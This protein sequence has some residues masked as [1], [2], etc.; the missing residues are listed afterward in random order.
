MTGV[1]IHA[2]DVPLDALGLDVRLGN[3]DHAGGHHPVQARCREFT[4]PGLSGLAGKQ[5]TVVIGYGADSRFLADVGHQRQLVV[6]VGER[7]FCQT[8]VS[9]DIHVPARHRRVHVRQLGHLEANAHVSG[10]LHDPGRRI[11]RIRL[12]EFL[13][14][15]KVGGAPLGPVLQD[16]LQFLSWRDGHVVD[17]GILR[18]LLLELQDQVVHDHELVAGHEQG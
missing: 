16:P 13:G 18:V 5:G 14:H 11:I 7:R 1:G 17:V 10:V 9:Q 2:P 15:G 3:P 8:V 6:G 4:I 12:D